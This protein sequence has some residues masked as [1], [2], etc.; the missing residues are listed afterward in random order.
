MLKLSLYTFLISLL[1]T[2]NFSCISSKQNKGFVA[3]SNTETVIDFTTAKSLLVIPVK[4]NGETKS[5]ILDNGAD[6][7]AINRQKII[8]NSSNVSGAD[9]KSALVGKETI[10]S[11]K[12][13]EMEFKDTY[14]LN[15]NF[16]SI[17]KEIP[18]FGGLIG[19]SVLAKANWLIDYPNKKLTITTKEINTAGFEIIKTKNIRSPFIFFEFEG[20]MYKAFV[21]LGST[22]ALSVKE[23]TEL[24]QLLKTKFS[25][26]EESKITTTISG[27]ATTQIK[28]SETKGIKIGSIVFDDVNTILVKASS[29][30][31][32]IGMDFFKNHQLYLDYTN[33]VFKIK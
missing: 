15:S 29:H 16:T 2:T 3:A 19:Q 1:C 7:T 27:T 23:N 8:G 17:E 32:R 25:F 18:N 11:M 5:F 9:G 4:L 13:G 30:D 22:T 24:A 14:A 31:I 20:K 12:I 28:R 33:K 6:L 10:N 21:D 26:K